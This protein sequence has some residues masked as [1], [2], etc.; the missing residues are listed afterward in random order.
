MAAE[1]LRILLVEDNADHAELIVRNL[2]KNRVANTVVR[3]PDGAAALDYMLRRGR[4]ED[5]DTSPRPQ[6]ILLDLRLPKVGGLEVLRTIKNTDAIQSIPIVI[7]TTSTA[8]RDIARAYEFHANSYVVK[9]LDFGKLTQTLSALA[10][11]WL[12]WNRP[13]W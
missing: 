3:L 6:L 12:G 5:P 7:V 13:P 9:P 10:A 8:D 2:R 4:F 1:P 11:Y